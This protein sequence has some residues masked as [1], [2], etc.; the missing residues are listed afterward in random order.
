[1]TPIE[2]TLVMYSQLCKEHRKLVKKYGDYFELESLELELLRCEA[3]LRNLGVD[4]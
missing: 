4:F 1:M 3:Q 2:E